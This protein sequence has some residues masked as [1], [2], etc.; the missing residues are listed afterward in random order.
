MSLRPRSTAR[1][2]AVMPRTL[3]AFRSAPRLMASRTAA[4]SPRL[5]PSNIASFGAMSVGARCAAAAAPDRAPGRA[6]GG[7]GVAGKGFTVRRLAPAVALPEETSCASAGDTARSSDNR[8]IPAD[9]TKDGALRRARTVCI[10]S[11]YLGPGPLANRQPPRQGGIVARE[12]W[13][14]HV[15]PRSA[16]AGWAAV[17]PTGARGDRPV[18]M[19]PTAFTPLGRDVRM[20]SGTDRRQLFLHP[21][22]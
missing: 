22:I 8:A 19:D 18:V 16:G 13:P 9:T 6:G 1:S 12:S 3:T 7:A 14:I 10:S 4:M 5:T 21:A 11:S 20:P 2:V 15:T 17:A